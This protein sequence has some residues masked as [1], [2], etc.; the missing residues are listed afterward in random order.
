MSTEPYAQSIA[1][2]RTVLAAVTADQLDL[3]TPCASWKVRDLI[4]HLVGAQYFFLAGFRGTPPSNAGE[5]ACVRVTSLAVRTT[6]RPPRR[7]RPSPRTARWAR[8]TPFRSAR[9]PAWPCSVWPPWTR[10]RTGG[11]SPRPRARAPISPP[12]SPRRCSAGADD[13]PAGIPR[14]RG[15]PVR[16]RADGTR[17]RHRART[18]SPRSSAAP[19]DQDQPWAAASSPSISVISSVCSLTICDAIRRTSSSEAVRLGVLG[20]VEHHPRG[21]W[22]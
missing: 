10:S 16:T 20:H 22:S 5:G 2:T 7:W 18:T 14:R 19:S 13:D 9:C 6:P 1:T 11:I 21:G 12:A 17:R 4:D 15:R 8:C 3:D